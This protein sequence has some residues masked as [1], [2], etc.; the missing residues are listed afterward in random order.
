MNKI[1]FFCF[2]AFISLS[3]FAEDNLEPKKGFIPNE[4]TAIK[5]A[6]AV[7]VPIYGEKLIESEKPFK[8]T[9]KNGIWTVTGS[10]PE[11]YLG[12]KVIAEISKETGCI[13]KVIH[14]Q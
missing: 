3:L 14:E 4:Q 12:G 2:I 10:L 9:L 11:G 13:I 6:V 8:A 1:I 5:I 7:W